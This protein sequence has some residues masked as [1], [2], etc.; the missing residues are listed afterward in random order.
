MR[1]ARRFIE[2]ISELLSLSATSRYKY[3][4]VW[5]SLSRSE[6]MAKLAVLGSTDEQV[7]ERSACNDFDRL[8]RTIRLDAESVVL[9]IGCGVGRLGKMFAP[10]CRTWTGCDVSP[11]ML[12]YARQRLGEFNNTRF[13]ELSG[14][15]LGPIADSSQDIVYSTVVFMH[16]TEWDR[17]NYILEARRVLKPGGQLYVDNISLTTEDGW[18]MFEESRSFPP[19]KRPPH[20]AS[21]STPQEFEV[22]LSRAGFASGRVEIVDNAW[23]V[24][25][26]VK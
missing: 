16:L 20:I 2:K 7:L 24:G 14:Y 8:L 13:V 18:K 11:G 10:V 23:V 25:T 21:A 1:P 22:Y 26:A 4:K 12:R 5:R 3:K 19:E 15:D 17:Y 9:E 6:G